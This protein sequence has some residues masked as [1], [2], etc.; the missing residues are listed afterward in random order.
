MTCEISYVIGFIFGFLALCFIII[1][2][3]MFD[4]EKKIE[5]NIS[6]EEVRKI[7]KIANKCLR[8]DDTFD[9]DKF[10]KLIGDLK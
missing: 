3:A 2:S 4:R 8:N 9:F 1:R 7:I 5:S 10:E 6:A